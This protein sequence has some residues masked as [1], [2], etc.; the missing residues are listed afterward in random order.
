MMINNI[1][2]PIGLGAA[3]EA[4]QKVVENSHTYYH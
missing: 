1:K 4:F 2:T 3:V